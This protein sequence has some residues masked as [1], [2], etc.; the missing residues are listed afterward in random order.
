M[1]LTTKL[2]LMLIPL[3][4]A[5]LLLVGAVMYFQLKNDAEQ[6]NIEQASALLN[7]IGTR[8]TRGIDTAKANVELIAD[9]QLIKKYLLTE[10]ESER[11]SLLQRPLEQK[12][13]SLQSVYPDYYELRILLPDGFEDIRVVE[14]WVE[15][16]TEQEG[17]TAYFKQLLTAAD[18]LRC[19]YALI[20]TMTS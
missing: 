4:A 19:G 17:N 1:K 11:Y 14:P 5:P 9:D 7:R 10:D 3:I 12:L 20:L 16:K 2:P 13:V 15:N 18:D 8:L 6:K